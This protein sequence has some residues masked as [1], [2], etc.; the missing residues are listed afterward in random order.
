MLKTILKT[1]NINLITE[2]FQKRNSFWKQIFNCINDH[3]KLEILFSLI[4]IFDEKGKDGTFEIIEAYKP[5]TTKLTNKY[6]DV[7]GFDFEL[8]QNQMQQNILTIIHTLIDTL[9]L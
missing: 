5:L 8:L 9:I 6:R 3:T 2:I 1:K 7:P 4:K